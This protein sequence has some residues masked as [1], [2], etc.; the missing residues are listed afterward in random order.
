MVREKNEAI[1]ACVVRSTQFLFY[2]SL[3]PTL[4]RKILS[5]LLLHAHAPANKVLDKATKATERKDATGIPKDLFEK[6]KG[7]V[8]I[9]VLEVGFIFSGNVGTGIVLAKKDDG[10]S[11]SNPVACGLTG[12]GWGLLVGGSVKDV[13]IFIMDENSLSGKVV[14]IFVSLF[15]SISC[16]A[17]RQRTS[18]SFVKLP[19]VCLHV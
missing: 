17:S 6:C 3:T 19:I 16:S 2:V 15:R 7:I 10:V 8:L 18:S 1:Y 5:E 14:N 9:S 13:M 12:V 11:W 4:D